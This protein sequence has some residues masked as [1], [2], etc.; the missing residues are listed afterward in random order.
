MAEILMNEPLE[1]HT[2][3]TDDLD[4]SPD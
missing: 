1:F 3:S 2:K 4:S